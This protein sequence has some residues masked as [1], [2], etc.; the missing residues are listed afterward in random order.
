M[1]AARGLMIQ[2]CCWYLIF[3]F[4]GMKDGGSFHDSH[5][6]RHLLG[7]SAR[8]CVPTLELRTTERCPSSAQAREEE[9]PKKDGMVWYGMVGVDVLG[10]RYGNRN[11]NRQTAEIWPGRA[12]RSNVDFC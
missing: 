12:L 2:G 1:S 4:S 8:E 7:C 11:R 10:V 3:F 9:S 5:F 6:R